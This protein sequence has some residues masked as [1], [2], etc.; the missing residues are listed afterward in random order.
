MNEDDK[1]ADELNRWID[2][3]E[4]TKEPKQDS[5]IIKWLKRN[6]SREREPNIDKLRYNRP[7]KSNAQINLI[8]YIILLI[9]II[10]ILHF[11][12]EIEPLIVYARNVSGILFL[13]LL[14]YGSWKYGWRGDGE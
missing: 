3:Q 4:G 11:L 9:P 7:P 13:V 8:I 5:K 6:M 14:F 10:I 1:L 12:S 2:E